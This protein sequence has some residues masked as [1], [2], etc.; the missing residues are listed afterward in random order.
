MY[1]FLRERERESER[2]G[3][4]MGRRKEGKKK[5]NKT[6]EKEKRKKKNKKR[7]R[8]AVGHSPLCCW[9]LKCFRRI[10]KVYINKLYICVTV[11]LLL[12]LALWPAVCVLCVCVHRENGEDSRITMSGIFSTFNF[13]SPFSSSSFFLIPFFFP[14]P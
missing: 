14:F 4:F 2:R 5:K 10:G 6:M 12:C 11:V 1:K 8:C 7:T 13:F 9:V 3:D